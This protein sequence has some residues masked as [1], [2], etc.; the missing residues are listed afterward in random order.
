LHFKILEASIALALFSTEKRIRS[1]DK[2]IKVKEHDKAI[3]FTPS[4]IWEQKT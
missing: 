2:S 3:F 4:V 1:L